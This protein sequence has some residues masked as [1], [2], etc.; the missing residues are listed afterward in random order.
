MAS[1]DE[2]L[3][4]TPPLAGIRSLVAGLLWF[5]I[6]VLPFTGLGGI[7]A[8]GEMK[9]SAS[10]YVLL[11]A[12]PL[13]FAACFRLDAVPKALWVFIP[14]LLTWIAIS[15]TANLG[16]IMWAEHGGRGGINKLITSLMVLGFGLSL[17][18]LGAQFL[19]RPAR[20]YRYFLVPLALSVLIA[21]LFA[22]PELLSW[23]SDAA[24]PLYKAT[25]G[26]FQTEEEGVWRGVGRLA[27]VSFEAPDLS[28]YSAFV[29]PWL[30]LGFRLARVQSSSRIGRLLFAIAFV[31]ALA[32]LVLSNS[33]TGMVMLAGWIAA[34]LA[35]WTVMRHRML[36]APFIA[37]AFFAIAVIA[38]YFWLEAAAQAPPFDIS[39]IS[40]LSTVLAQ[41]GLAADHPVFGVG[42]GQYG[43]QALPYLPSWAWESFEIIWWFERETMMP[44]AFSVPGRL[45]AEI[46]VPGLLIWYGFWAWVMTRSASLASRLP[47][48]S[49]ALYINAA[50][51]GSTCCVVV[52]GVS[53]DC[54]RRPE[55]WLVMGATAAFLA[56]HRRPS[57]T[58]AVE[59]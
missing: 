5:A 11:L 59:R 16:A 56:I 43:F 3:G 20:L 28:Y 18:L 13:F 29:L 36:P 50:I 7:G 53:S 58:Q 54:F 41:F 44:P 45:A 46:G 22:V 24:L 23:I 6:L 14:L 49:A 1:I 57:P 19:D 27:S 32:L 47:S 37:A 8:M 38:V 42:W 9:G 25:T 51:I 21:G 52:G 26:L 15:A 33:R 48:G 55:T 39:T 35:Y 10:T 31:T 40:R 17:T 2:T 34:E 4:Y 12:M 30:V